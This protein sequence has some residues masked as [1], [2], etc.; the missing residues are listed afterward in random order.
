MRMVAS[1]EISTYNNRNLL[2]LVHQDSYT[3]ISF[4]TSLSKTSNMKNDNLTRLGIEGALAKKSLQN[5]NVTDVLTATATSN[6]VAT[7]NQG[8][9][10]LAGCLTD[11]EERSGLMGNRRLADILYNSQ[12]L[13]VTITERSEF[14]PILPPGVYSLPDFVN[15]MQ[16]QQWKMEEAETEKA[17]PEGAYVLPEEAYVILETFN[18]LYEYFITHE[19]AKVFH[20][21]KFAGNVASLRE[22]RFSRKHWQLVANFGEKIQTCKGNTATALV[23]GIYPCYDLFKVKVKIASIEENIEMKAVTFEEEDVEGIN[24]AYFLPKDVV[25]FKR[26]IPPTSWAYFMAYSMIYFM[27][28]S[29]A[30]MVPGHHPSLGHR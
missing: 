22:I 8:D 24:E 21:I 15:A 3:T 30:V 16:V 20:P 14:L 26:C 9:E 18:A 28:Y 5:E 27:A 4:N 10:K 25:H 19:E 7:R 6:E 11:D 29:M 2:S 1:F 12:A 17:L 13:S 23:I